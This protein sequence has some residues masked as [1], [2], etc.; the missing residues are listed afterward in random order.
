VQ[1]LEKFDRVAVSVDAAA[2]SPT[3]KYV[4]ARLGKA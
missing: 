2:T 1:I 4:V 3:M